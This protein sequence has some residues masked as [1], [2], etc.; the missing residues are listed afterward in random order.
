MLRVGLI[1]AGFMGGMHA[2]CYKAL[3]LNVKITAVADVVREKAEKIAGAA[4]AEVYDSGE[5]LIESADVDIIDICLP[6]YLHTEHA[7]NAMNKGLAVFIEKPVCLLPE[8]GELLLQTQKKTNGIVMVGH[9]IRFWEEYTWLKKAIEEELFGKVISAIF[10]RISPKPTWAWDGWLLDPDRSG[11]AALD[12]HIHDTDF[13]RSIF[14]EPRGVVSEA[15]RDN[16]RAINQILTSYIYRDKLVLAEGAWGYPPSF[17]FSMEYRVMFEHA[18]AVYKSGSIPSLVVYESG[19][20]V[21]TPEFKKEDIG[22]NVTGG[23]FSELG[24]YYN[25]LK[26]FTEQIINQREIEEATLEESIKSF[27][28]VIREIDNAGGL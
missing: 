4:E 28:L 8:E 22:T 9:C 27:N 7:V 15:A 14:G 12:L 23:N 17:P 21:S 13:I 25:E 5:K 16:N 26:Y 2:A 24:G 3:G 6:T 1:G 20:G 18:T 19:G 10:T 11:S